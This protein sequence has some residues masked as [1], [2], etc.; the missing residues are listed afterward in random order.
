MN[1]FS[2]MNSNKYEYTNNTIII[3]KSAF[4]K[5]KKDFGFFEAFID[6]DFS[7][8]NE[9]FDKNGNYILKK[10]L[11]PEEMIYYDKNTDDTYTIKRNQVWKALPKALNDYHVPDRVL[12]DYMANFFIFKT[13]KNSLFNPTIPESNTIPKANGEYFPRTSRAQL[14]K[15]RRSQ[16]EVELLRS[17]LNGNLNNNNEYSPYLFSAYHTENELRRF[18]EEDKRKNKINELKM[19][20][21]RNKNANVEELSEALQGIYK[22]KQLAHALYQTEKAMSNRTKYRKESETRKKPVLE[23][24]KEKRR[25]QRREKQRMR[26]TMMHSRPN[27]NENRNNEN[28]ENNEEY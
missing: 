1:G 16:K 25:T 24:K 14:K 10:S 26:K 28:N 7:N 15:Q 23:T 20:L 18:I 8:S 3:P 11:L 22:N 21:K 6:R 19:Q 5:L 13:H 12:G 4:S 2:N 9:Y 17:E 27:N